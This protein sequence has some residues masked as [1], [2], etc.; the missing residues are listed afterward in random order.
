MRNTNTFSL[1]IIWLQ[2][3]NTFSLFI[4]WLQYNTFSLFIICSFPLLLQLLA[5]LNQ[6]FYLNLSSWPCFSFLVCVI[7]ID[8]LTDAIQ[9]ILCI[10]QCKSCTGSPPTTHSF[11]IP[12]GFPAGARIYVEYP[13]HLSVDAAEQDLI[14]LL[15]PCLRLIFCPSGGT[16]SQISRLSEVPRLVRLLVKLIVK[17]C[18]IF[19]SFHKRSNQN[20]SHPLV[21]IDFSS[22]PNAPR[23]WLMELF[24]FLGRFHSFSC[25]TLSAWSEK[26]VLLFFLSLIYFFCNF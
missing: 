25:L 6:P 26:T 17:V 13:E 22:L 11:V 23:V 4:I 8:D 1:F 15:S 14:S 18:C 3:T 19:W 24:H 10:L 5:F 21:Q 9:F 2:N 7:N 20:F 16:A 12:G